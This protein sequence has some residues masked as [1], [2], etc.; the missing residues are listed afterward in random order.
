M[1][2]FSYLAPLPHVQCC[3]SHTW[4]VPGVSGKVVKDELFGLLPLTLATWFMDDGSNHYSTCTLKA[5]GG[6]ELGC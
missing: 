3:H 4:D 1:W 2:V 5:L 6:R